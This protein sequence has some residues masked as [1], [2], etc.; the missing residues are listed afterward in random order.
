M[1]FSCRTFTTPT[2]ANELSHYHNRGFLL[3]L[4]PHRQ[5]FE[6][7]R[8]LSEHPSVIDKELQ[9]LLSQDNLAAF[10]RRLHLFV[11]FVLNEVQQRGDAAVFAEAEKTDRRCLCDGPQEE[12]SGLSSDSR[13]ATATAEEAEAARAEVEVK[14]EAEPYLDSF[15]PRDS[16][17][18]ADPDRQPSPSIGAPAPFA[19]SDS[20]S[21]LTAAAVVSSALASASPFESPSASPVT[22]LVDVGQVQTMAAAAAAAA[23]NSGG[24]PSS[25]KDD[26][27]SRDESVAVR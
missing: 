4:I 10:K 3:S 12:I 14:A 11:K 1:L 17:S 25:D 9:F 27:S 21:A 26:S 24:V 2:V 23:H 13:S 7:C 5:L 6:R 19:L 18:A 15:V 8:W 20:A 16:D 22:P